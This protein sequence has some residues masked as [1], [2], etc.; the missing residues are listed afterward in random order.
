MIAEV[1]APDRPAVG[2]Y[3]IWQRKSQNALRDHKKK[4]EKF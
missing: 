1:C 3:A 4:A 2:R